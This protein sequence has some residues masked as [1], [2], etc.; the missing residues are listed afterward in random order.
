MDK[1]KTTAVIVVSPTAGQWE[2]RGAADLAKYIELMAGAKP[3][4]AD[5]QGAIEAALKAK[6]PVFVV[7]EE[8]LKAEPSLREAL[9]KV[10]K[11]EPFLRAD[12][13]VAR[14]LGNR[15]YLA[16]TND[17]SHYYAVSYLLQQWGCRWYLPTDFGECIPTQETL[18]IGQLNYAYAPPFEVRHYW[19]SWN[20]DN[21]GAEEFQKRNF[22]SSTKVAGMGHALAQYTKDIVPPAKRRSM[23]RSPK[24]PQRNTSPIKS[25]PNMPKAAAAFRW[26]LKMVLTPPIRPKTTN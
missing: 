7:G 9:A 3:V 19:L 6:T 16:G 20:A 5:T 12:A 15:V 21:T 23:C 8:A 10:A 17:E 13:I 14:R 26:R 4:I 24:M 18:K 11:K 25:R 1:Q 2:K 22:M